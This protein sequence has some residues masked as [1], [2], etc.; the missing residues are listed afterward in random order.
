MPIKMTAFK[1]TKICSLSRDNNLRKSG[2]WQIRIIHI[3]CFCR[4]PFPLPIVL[5]H[6][7]QYCIS[8]HTNNTILNNILIGFPARGFRFEMMKRTNL[9][10]INFLTLG[11]QYGTL[12]AKRFQRAQIHNQCIIISKRMKPRLKLGKGCGFSLGL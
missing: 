11:L 7:G 3:G 1:C 5:F 9:V 8:F 12:S 2:N 10:S 6:K 4:L